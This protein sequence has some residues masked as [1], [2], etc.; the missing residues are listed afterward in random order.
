Y[1][2]ND[3]YGEPIVGIFY[4][5]ELVKVVK[6]ADETYRIEKILKTRQRKGLTEH[7]VKWVGYPDK[8]NQWIKGTDLKLI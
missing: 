5:W 7:F 8:F 1:K 3:W 6:S 4:D 2:V